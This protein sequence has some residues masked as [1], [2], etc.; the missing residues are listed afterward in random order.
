M[1]LYV[2]SWPR[3]CLYAYLNSGDYA[4]VARFADVAG[5]VLFSL[6]FPE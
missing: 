3:V 2:S 1:V 5:F 6:S 4:D